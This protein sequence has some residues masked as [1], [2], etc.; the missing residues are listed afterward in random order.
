M[1]IAE[2][3]RTRPAGRRFVLLVLVVLAGILGMHAL[4]PG[5]AAAPPAVAAAQAAAQAAATTG[6]HAATDDH[7]AGAAAGHGSAADGHDSGT[8]RAAGRAVEDCSHTA[9]GSG[10][11]DHADATCAAAGV[12][13]TYVPPALLPAL[14][15][16]EAGTSLAS[17]VPQGAAGSRAPPDLAELQLLRI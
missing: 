5:P 7:R 12:S 17:A 1:V 16:P 3:P 15:V 10:H 6:G 8:G 2:Q 4:T 14:V 11:V 9:G 13:T